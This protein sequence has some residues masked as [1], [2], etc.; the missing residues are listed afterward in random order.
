MTETKELANVERVDKISSIIRNFVTIVAVIGGAWWTVHTFS[1][2]GQKVKADVEIE[3]L[4]HR[5]GVLDFEVKAAEKTLAND[6]NHYV[7][8]AVQITNVGNSD[9]SMCF[10]DPDD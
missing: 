4:R 5:E 3:D 2:L 9:V 7:E 8:I 1:V 10:E 6:K